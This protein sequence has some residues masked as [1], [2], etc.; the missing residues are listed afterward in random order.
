LVF[1]VGFSAGKCPPGQSKCECS[2][3]Y[4]CTAPD[5]G[6]PPK[7]LVCPVGSVLTP[8]KHRGTCPVVPPIGAA[9]CV[10]ACQNDDSC[11]PNEKC[12]SNGCGKMCTIAIRPD[13]CGA[14]LHSCKCLGGHYCVTAGSICLSPTSAC[15]GALPIVTVVTPVVTTP[16]ITPVITAP[17][18]VVS[19]PPPPHFNPPHD[20]FNPPHN[21][22]NS[23]G[24]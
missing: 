15:P 6:C 12:C 2:G 3:G 14:G 19:A 18:I 4:Y 16:V 8:P 9:P 23:R 21:D 13:A 7:T 17:V 5:A 20:D 10:W 22:H 24:H 11:P 1:V